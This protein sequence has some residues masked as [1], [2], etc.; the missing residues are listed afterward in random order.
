MEG[1]TRRYQNNA[2][3][4]Q[5]VR[6]DVAHNCFRNSQFGPF[7]I[8]SK[9]QMVYNVYIWISCLEEQKTLWM[10]NACILYDILTEFKTTTPQPIYAP[11]FASFFDR[12]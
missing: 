11:D 6:L 1:K 8:L 10:Y 3:A 5:K 4:A 2:K 7:E 9:H 12:H